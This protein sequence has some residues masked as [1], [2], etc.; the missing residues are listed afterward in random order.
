MTDELKPCKRCGASGKAMYQIY[1][2][3]TE[4]YW[5]VCMNRFCGEE[6]GTHETQEAATREW[7]E[8]SEEQLLRAEVERLRAQIEAMKA[9]IPAWA[10]EEMDNQ[11]EDEAWKNL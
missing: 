1:S 9:W 5:V 11:E 8:P 6:T 7:N 10:I 3:G 4:D 2:D